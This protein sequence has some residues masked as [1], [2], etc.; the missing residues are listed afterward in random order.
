M[1]QNYQDIFYRL[2]LPELVLLAVFGVL[3]LLRLLYLFLFS[4]KI[5][6]RKKRKNDD[7]KQHPFSLFITVRNEEEKLKKNLPKIFSINT[8]DFEMVVV[9]DFSQDNSYL[10]LG[11]LRDRYKRLTIST[12]NQETRFSVKLAQNIGIKATQ[13]EWVVNIP[14]SVTKPTPEWLAGISE[15]IAENKNMVVG[16]STVITEKGYYNRLFRIENYHQFLKS[17]GYIL[18]GIPL[19]FSDENVA[20]K[21]EKYFEI[22]GYGQKVNEPYANLELLFNLFIRKKTTTILFNKTSA[23]RKAEQIGRAE[24]FELLKKS[25]RIE[26][27]LSPSKKL[28]LFIDEIGKLLFLPL[29]AVII[30]LLPE[31][32]IPVSALLGFKFLAHLVIIKITQNR[33]NESKI[34]I[35]SLVYELIMPYY[36]LFFR[37][38]FNRRS[39]KNRWRSKV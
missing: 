11:L 3:F 21:K 26:K 10:I 31:F 25:I 39:K 38:H 36:K 30:I 4:G 37:W 14:V 18:N 8:V 17:T 34:F 13:N 28:F 15:S 24:Y 12:L 9:D 7:V 16:Y 19:V 23:I 29:A 6:F 1:I 22:G 32:W 20:F 27:H 5:L 35:P 33:L 2:P